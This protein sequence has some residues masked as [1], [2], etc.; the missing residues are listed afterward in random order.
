MVA[1]LPPLLSDQPPD[2][3]QR[4]GLGDRFHY[5][6]GRSGHRYLFSAVRPDE[7][8][9]FESAVVIR[10]VPAGRGRLA[11]HAI[12]VIDHCGR[13][14]DGRHPWPRLAAAS[15]RVLVHLLTD[16]EAGRHELVDDIAGQSM[17]IAA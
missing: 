10:A 6:R 13:P 4:A 3:A 16:D 2:L 7:L 1:V 9:A 11:A 14:L 8:A 17:A 5:F 15:E 12:S